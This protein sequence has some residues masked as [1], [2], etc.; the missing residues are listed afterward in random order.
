ML[1]Y[2]DIKA[3]HF[4]NIGKSDQLNDTTL[5]ADF[6]YNLGNRYQLILANIASYINESPR[7]D[8]TAVGTQYYDYPPGIVSLDNISI[9]IGSMQYTLSPIYNQA[10]WNQLNSLQIQPSAIP[11]FYFPRKSDY[12]I[13]PKPNGIYTINF[14]TFDRD[15]N[16][17]VE[18]YVTGTITLTNGDKTVEGTSTTF[19]SAMVGRFLTVTDTTV[20]G[21]GYWYRVASITNTTHLELDKIWASDTTAVAVTYRIGECPQIPDEA[22]ILLPNGTASDYYGGMRND[23]TNANIFDNLFWTGSRSNTSRDKN[24]K[25]ISAGLIGLIK[26]YEDRDKNTLIYRLQRPMSPYWKVFATTIS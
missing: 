21:Q 26:N 16:M 1:T 8:S 18:D 6:N 25:N 12:G 23:Q 13:W 7:T 24:D 5:L 2:T 11:Q 4:R 19:T 10:S 3:A 14:F 9:T 17:A 15:R 20:P 22:H